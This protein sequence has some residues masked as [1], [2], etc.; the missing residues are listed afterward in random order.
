MP[1]LKTVF[2][3]IF[4]NFMKT[5]LREARSKYMSNHSTVRISLDYQLLN[6]DRW[7]SLP[8]SAT[9]YFDLDP[10]EP[11]SLNACPHHSHAI[12]YLPDAAAAIATTKLTLT[13]VQSQRQ[14]VETFWNHGKNR[15]IERINT[16]KTPYSETILEVQISEDLLYLGNLAPQTHRWA[17][18][19]ALSRLPAKERQ[20]L[21]N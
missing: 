3:L 1:S 10:D 13:D 8:L 18:S 16:G 12:D 6:S 9:D 7:E 4:D 11:P 19:A 21:P 5:R 15:L 14:I 2:L 17:A 20:R